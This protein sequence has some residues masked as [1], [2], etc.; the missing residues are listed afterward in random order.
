MKLSRRQSL[1]LA[2]GAAALPAISRVAQAQSYPTRPIT[3]VVP[4]AAGGASDVIARLVAQRMKAPLGQPVI[5]E[6]VT[7]AGGSIAVGRVARAAADGYTL[8]EGQNGSHVMNGATY[9][10]P[11]DL[12]NDFEPIALLAFAPVL[13][14]AKKAVPADDLK[15]LIAWLTANPDKA[16]MGHSGNGGIGHVA[17]VRF[18]IETGTRFRFVPYRGAA[19]TLQDLV[20]GQIDLQFGDT[21]SV[22]QVRTGRVKAYAITA[23]APLASAPDIPTVDRAGLPGFYVSVWNALWAP[24]RT[25]QNIIAKLNAAVVEALADP[26]VRARLADLDQEIFPREQQTPEALGALQKAEIEKWWPIIKA[27]NIKG[28]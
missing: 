20:A 24:K 1:H 23:P 16:I 8:S 17:G 6:N 10:L 3:V 14:L 4:Y 26:G 27:A 15:G 25:P 13:L 5:I 11:Y 18:Q 19:A 9:R 22:T 7:G 28:E 2:A 12:L 21:T